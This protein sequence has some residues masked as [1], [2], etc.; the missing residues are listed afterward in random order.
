MV[1]STGS[2]SLSPRRSSSLE[3][4]CRHRP[5]PLAMSS[6]P[7][8]TIK[9]KSENKTKRKKNRQK[10]QEANIK[11]TP[12]QCEFPR[13]QENGASDQQ[14]GPTKQSR[15]KS[16]MDEQNT[17]SYTPNTHIH[18]IRCPRTL[19]H[20]RNTITVHRI[21]VQDSQKKKKWVV[22]HRNTRLVLAVHKSSG[23][24]QF[25][26]NEEKRKRFKRC[27]MHSASPPLRVVTFPCGFP[28]FHS[29]SNVLPSVQRCHPCEIM[30]SAVRKKA[31][32]KFG[33]AATTT[34]ST[35]AELQYIARQINHNR[36]NQHV[37]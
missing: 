2:L 8:K 29:P 11:N 21:R 35:T 9:K 36:G 25:S 19:A 33:T 7:A 14:I 13:N 32:G 4:D 17:Q 24:W 28:S 6:S 5:R 27:P 12:N 3:R 34:R 23:R 31:V 20:S 37:P 1:D 15:P 18:K 22:H 26:R 10:K 16:A 30:P